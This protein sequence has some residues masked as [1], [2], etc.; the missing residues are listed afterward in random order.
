M[1][2]YYLGKLK[3]GSVKP[4]TFVYELMSKMLWLLAFAYYISITLAFFQNFDFIPPCTYKSLRNYWLFIGNSNLNLDT[5]KLELR[6][7]S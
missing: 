4:K 1:S 2:Y 7:H 5:G 3:R 6:E